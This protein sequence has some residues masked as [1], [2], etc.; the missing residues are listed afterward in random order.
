MNHSQSPFQPSQHPTIVTAS[1]PAL[2]S[3]SMATLHPSPSPTSTSPSSASPQSHRVTPYTSEQ[4][5]H[6]LDD[7]QTLLTA[8]IE[9][10]NAG[11][12]GSAATYLQR[13][14]SNLLILASLA[15]TYPP[16]TNTPT[17]AAATPATASAVSS[18]TATAATDAT[19]AAPVIAT[20]AQ[21]K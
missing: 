10:A 15:D 18:S 16:T 4:V 2:A 14:Q 13:L 1:V 17:L 20:A 8:V 19:T 21:N 9:N 3:S 7:N 5:Q 11:K 6:F 12:L